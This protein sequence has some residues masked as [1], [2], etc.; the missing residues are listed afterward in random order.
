MVRQS[1]NSAW[2]Y[3]MMRYSND[4]VLTSDSLLCFKLHILN[5]D[6]TR[7][8]FN[9]IP[10]QNNLHLSVEFLTKS[11]IKRSSNALKNTPELFSLK[12]FL[13]HDPL[14]LISPSFVLSI[15]DIMF[16]LFLNLRKDSRPSFVSIKFTQ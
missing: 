14:F 6:W 12:L 1:E 8:F 9:P 5:L 15:P 10:I 3:R 7:K 16:V 13:Y 2:R 11:K 4:K